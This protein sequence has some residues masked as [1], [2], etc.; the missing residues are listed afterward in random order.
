M[1][2]ELTETQKEHL[3]RFT[4]QQKERERNRIKESYK[5]FCK[6]VEGYKSFGFRLFA[7]EP[8]PYIFIT[9]KEKA[10]KEHKEEWALDI[11]RLPSEY[12]KDKKT[13]NL[14][15]KL[16]SYLF[17]EDKEILNILKKVKEVILNDNR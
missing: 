8:M 12:R 11:L 15:L 14:H 17:K 4:K 1:K 3:N 7:K 10:N 9:S 5:T 16:L 13:I 2:I 6:E